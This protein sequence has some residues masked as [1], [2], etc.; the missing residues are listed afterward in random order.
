MVEA[1]AGYGPTVTSGDR[2]T[3]VVSNKEI[4]QNGQNGDVTPF[5]SPREPNYDLELNNGFMD[6]GGISLEDKSVPSNNINSSSEELSVNV[7]A[8]K[9]QQLTKAID[10][11]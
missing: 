3:V 6:F 1:Y 5:N 4:E 11:N 10:R 7:L 2:P 8:R 9:V